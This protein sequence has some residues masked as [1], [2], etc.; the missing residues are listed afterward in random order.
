M[1]SELVVMVQPPRCRA[2][3]EQKL[4]PFRSQSF[5]RL[6]SLGAVRRVMS[7]IYTLRILRK[8][9]GGTAIELEQFVI[10]PTDDNNFSIRRQTVSHEALD[11][12]AQGLI[13]AQV[14]ARGFFA[15]ACG[16]CIY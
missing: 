3:K 16:V 9:P 14:N 5:E 12:S 7:R 2:R 8:M 15:Q 4:A 10:S 1:L 6:N 13:L 11:P